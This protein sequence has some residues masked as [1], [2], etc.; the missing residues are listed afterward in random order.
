MF[1]A[2]DSAMTAVIERGRD[3]VLKMPAITIFVNA[4]LANFIKSFDLFL[5]KNLK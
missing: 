5:A 2:G 3:T 1:S 4:E